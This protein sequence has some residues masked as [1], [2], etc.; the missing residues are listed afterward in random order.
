VDAAG[1]R[2]R[3]R[4]LATGVNSAGRTNG[5]SLPSQEAQA[6]LLEKIYADAAIDPN[7]LAFIEGHGTG[8]KVG[9]PAEVWAIGQVLGQ[10]RHAP[11]PLGSIKTN[12][13]HTEPA[14][15]LFGVLKAVMALEH[16]YLPASL[17][18]DTPNDA[19][20]FNGL[21][22]S[23]T[24]TPLPLLRSQRPRLAGI[25]SFGFGGTNAHV[26]VSDPVSRQ[27][28]AAGN[29]AES[30]YFMVSAHTETALR[31]LLEDY[32]DRLACTADQASA[33]ALVAAAT[34]GRTPL[35][36]RFVTQVRKPR[37]IV[38]V[39]AWLPPWARRRS[40]NP[41]SPSCL[42]A[43]ARNGPAWV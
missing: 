25:N 18:F 9:D 2:S 42:L 24:S 23:V 27:G 28:A 13:G 12:I 6:Q 15:G 34:A 19:I 30:G 36:H 17:F 10:K 38:A 43:T 31:T 3:A 11:I 22:V 41:G 39:P 33:P 21:N 16:D 26:V 4:I 29:A 14:S 32:R 37:D 8:T 5:I 1:D 40:A 20:D 7:Q 35:R